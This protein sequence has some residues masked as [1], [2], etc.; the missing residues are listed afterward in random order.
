[1]AEE[2]PQRLRVEA[3]LVASAVAQVARAV[4]KE[5][6]AAALQAACADTTTAAEEVSSGSDSER[7]A[8][9]A[10][11]QKRR[12][13]VARLARVLGTRGLES[14]DEEAAGVQLRPETS[15]GSSSSDSD[16]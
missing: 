7:A 9:V 2:E 8:V 10:R 3:A 16:F 1:M 6:L 4:E 5:V 15:P 11:D 13:A 12:D 14:S